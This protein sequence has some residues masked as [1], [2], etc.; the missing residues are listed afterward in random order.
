MSKYFDHTDV[1][2]FKIVTAVGIIV[3]SFTAFYL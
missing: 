3:F 2:F 1:R